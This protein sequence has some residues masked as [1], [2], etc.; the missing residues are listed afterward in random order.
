[1]SNV[2]TKKTVKIKENDLVDLIDKLVSETLVIK[3]KEWL[4][5]QAK[6][7]TNKTA[8]LESRILALEKLISKK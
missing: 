1:M 7:A 3:K 6:K 8:V 2:N 5:E 4:S